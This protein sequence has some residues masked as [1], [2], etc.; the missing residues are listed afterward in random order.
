MRSC[1]DSVCKAT[2]RGASLS[3]PCYQ[4]LARLRCRCY[5]SRLPLVPHL[6]IWDRARGR[7][8]IYRFHLPVPSSIGNTVVVRASTLQFLLPG[9]DNQSKRVRKMHSNEFRLLWSFLKPTRFCLRPPHEPPLE[10]SNGRKSR[11]HESF[12]NPTRLYS[13]TELRR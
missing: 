5:T 1:R 4:L 12:R 7:K 6:P 13:D 11:S 10:L 8:G 3:L 9:E 2:Y